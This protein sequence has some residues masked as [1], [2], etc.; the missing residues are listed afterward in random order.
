[1]LEVLNELKQLDDLPIS[2]N[3]DQ[4]ILERTIN[5]PTLTQSLRLFGFMIPALLISPV[6]SLPGAMIGGLLAGATTT[7]TGVIATTAACIG[8]V[9]NGAL[10][11]PIG[12]LALLAAGIATTVVSKI[13]YSQYFQSPEVWDKDFLQ[14]KAVQSVLDLLTTESTISSI[15]ESIAMLVLQNV[16]V[17]S[18]NVDLGNSI[19]CSSRRFF[20]LET[21]FE[22]WKV[23]S[24]ELDPKTLNTQEIYYKVTLFSNYQNTVVSSR[25]SKFRE[26]YL[27]L[28][29]SFPEK[30]NLLASFPPRTF[31]KSTEIGFL[32]ER[33]TLLLNWI[34]VIE[35]D[36]IL[37]ESQE[38]QDFF[39]LTQE[40]SDPFNNSNSA[41]L[42][43]DWKIVSDEKTEK[44]KNIDEI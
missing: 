28:C 38:V 30:T 18:E 8:G 41:S 5:G 16:S 34:K 11:A 7:T 26:L 4:P 6:L 36:E 15:K 43:D 27:K 14:R 17:S 20:S 32:K 19:L 10:I 40:P 2:I 3:F 44:Y 22:T 42:L 24:V 25:F 29:T 12:G 37:S 13:D 1:M 33:C 39:N 31:R 23:L 35:S 9:I 21:N